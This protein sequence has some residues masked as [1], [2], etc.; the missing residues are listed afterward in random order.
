MKKAAS[1]PRMD[2]TVIFTRWLQCAPCMLP[3]AHPSPQLKR[4][5]DQFSHFCTAHGRASL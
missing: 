1:T 2:G 4:H 3:W 5:L